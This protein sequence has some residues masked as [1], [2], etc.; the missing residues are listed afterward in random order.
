MNLSVSSPGIKPWVKTL[1]LTLVFFI[2]IA[3]L[4]EAFFRSGWAGVA[5]L[6]PTTGYR[7]ADDAFR[8]NFV[9]V[10]NLLLSKFLPGQTGIES[11][12]RSVFSKLRWFWRVFSWLLRGDWESVVLMVG[13]FV[14]VFLRCR[15]S[16]LF[17]QTEQ[18]VLVVAALLTSGGFWINFD[19]VTRDS[20]MLIILLAPFAG[21]AIIWGID[22]LIRAGQSTRRLVLLSSFEGLAIGLLFLLGLSDSFKHQDFLY[23]STACS[24]TAQ[25]QMADELNEMLEPEQAVLGI[26]SLWYH[27]LTGQQNPSPVIQL[28]GLAKRS[29]HASGWTEASIIENYEQT[30]PAVVMIWPNPEANEFA[31][32]LDSNYVLIGKLEPDSSGFAQSLYVRRGNPEISDLIAGWPF[33]VCK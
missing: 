6:Y 15:L 5:V 12:S 33:I 13:G 26:G 23:S 11:E 32:W 17:H 1:I 24:L 22:Y 9:A 21:G 20:I 2:L 19:G 14:L 8:Q 4:S 10:W 28:D 16:D 3:S 31:G 27:T 29:L 25:Q 7:S 18:S 30:E